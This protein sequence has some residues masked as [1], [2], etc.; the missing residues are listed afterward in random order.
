MLT[1]TPGRLLDHLVNTA[2]LD[3]S[4]LAWLVLDEADR[5]LDMGFRE[6]LGDIVKALEKR[7]RAGRFRRGT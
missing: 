4:R 1:G 2:S 7:G 5:L 3:T 6:V